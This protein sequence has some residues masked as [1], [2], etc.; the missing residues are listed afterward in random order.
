MSSLLPLPC[1]SWPCLVEFDCVQSV[2]LWTTRR[3]VIVVSVLQESRSC[4]FFA[5]AN[6]SFGSARSRKEASVERANSR[7]LAYSV[8]VLLYLFLVRCQQVFNVLPMSN[9]F[10]LW[11]CQQAGG[12]S[13]GTD[14]SLILKLNDIL[15][16]L[17]LPVV[18][19]AMA[20]LREVHQTMLE[21]QL[22]RLECK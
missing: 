8:M 5:S 3:G 19:Q 7:L 18:W 17:S 13:A 15:F 1:C 22:E 14:V 2:A 4:N 10:A 6:F 21:T 9:N 16:S 11:W 12:S 20:H